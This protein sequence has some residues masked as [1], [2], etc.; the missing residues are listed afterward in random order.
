MAWR[1]AWEGHVMLWQPLGSGHAQG[2]GGV[3]AGDLS[4]VESTTLLQ[5]SA[6]S[7]PLHWIEHILVW[8]RD[9]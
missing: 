7:S 2:A 5:M 1:L 6:Q 3:H 9:S 4:P 8:W